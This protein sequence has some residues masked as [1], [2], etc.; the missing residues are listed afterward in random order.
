MTTE[1]LKEFSW[2]V[3]SADDIQIQSKDISYVETNP[4]SLER[5]FPSFSKDSFNLN[6]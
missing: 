2:D 4:P 5:N 6:S 3:E 1:E